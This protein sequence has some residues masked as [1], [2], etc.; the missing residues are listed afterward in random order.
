MPLRRRTAVGPA[1]EVLR[2]LVLSRSSVVACARRTTSR[3]CRRL[4]CSLY[5]AGFVIVCAIC[6]SSHASHAR[7]CARS[8]ASSRPRRRGR[9]GAAGGGAPPWPSA[10]AWISHLNFHSAL[11]RPRPRIHAVPRD[12]DAEKAIVGRT[13]HTHTRQIQK[14][15]A[16]PDADRRS[17]DNAPPHPCPHACTRIA[18]SAFASL[19]RRAPP[20]VAP[21]LPPAPAA[22]SHGLL[23]RSPHL[24]A[25]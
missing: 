6:I 24:S 21:P 4:G 5:V 22:T 1:H 14:Y 20:L 2:I 17:N 13:H 7:V 3:A 10:I 11:G 12:P 23:A 8:C 25:P 18:L 16:P 9:R 19:A 15:S